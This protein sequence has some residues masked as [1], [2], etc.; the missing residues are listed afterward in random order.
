MAA[1]RNTLDALLP[2]LPR[3]QREI[4]LHTAILEVAEMSQLAE[5]ASNCKIRP[6]LLARLSD[7]VALV[8]PGYAS[9]LESALLASGHTPKKVQGN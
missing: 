5:L 2:L 8:D 9:Q 4:H 7:T 1:P 6:Y 3:E